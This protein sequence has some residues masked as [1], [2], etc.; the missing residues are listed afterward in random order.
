[1][2]VVRSVSGFKNPKVM[3]VESI[4]N[5]YETT[6]FKDNDVIDFVYKNRSDTAEIYEVLKNGLGGQF[7]VYDQNGKRRCYAN[8]NT[9][10]DI[11]VGEYSFESG[12][13][14]CDGLKEIESPSKLNNE[15]DELLINLKTISNDD[16]KLTDLPEADYYYVYYWS[17]FREKEKWR[18]QDFNNLKDELSKANE[19]IVMLRINCDLLDEWGLKESKRVAIKFRKRSKQKYEMTFGAIPFK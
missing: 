17:I 19:K 15:I 2:Q 8:K 11:V 4:Q 16:L 1:M 6:G 5:S 18:I 3:N 10:G 13:G 12:L 14:E 7:D 9:C